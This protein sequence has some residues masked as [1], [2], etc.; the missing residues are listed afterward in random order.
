MLEKKSIVEDFYI[1]GPAVAL[2]PWA[3]ESSSNASRAQVTCSAGPSL[4]LRIMTCNHTSVVPEY[5]A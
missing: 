4:S 1:Q 2:V 5:R 3:S